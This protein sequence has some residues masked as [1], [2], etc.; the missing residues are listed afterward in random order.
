[1]PQED[2]IRGLRVHSTTLLFFL[3]GIT[4]G[5]YIAHYCAKQ[6]KAINQRLG[7]E[8]RIPAILNATLFLLSYSSITLSIGHFIFQENAAIENTGGVVDWIL[9]ISLLTWGF[10]ARNRMNKLLASSRDQT[11]WFSGLWTFLFTP[12]YFN[13]KINVLS[14]PPAGLQIYSYP[15][16]GSAER[17]RHLEQQVA[18]KMQS[19]PSLRAA[20]AS[21]ESNLILERFATITREGSTYRLEIRRDTEIGP[22]DIQTDFSNISELGTYL[23]ERT[24]FR[25]R[26]F[27]SR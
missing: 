1:M 2:L 25:I 26:D 15:A 16:W 18:L 27:V 5:A 17:Q 3:S 19:Q 12:L 4:F 13:Y 11:T 14:E 23:S 20:I 6:S 9:T 24:A 8:E 22:L 7:Q 21:K 10:M